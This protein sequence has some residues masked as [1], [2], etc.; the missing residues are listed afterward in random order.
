MSDLPR[1]VEFYEEGPR[2]GFQMEARHYSLEDRA[3]LVNAL[4]ET[5]LKHIQVASFVHPE[6]VP[7]MAD[8]E[9]L[10]QAITPREGVQYT[11]IWLNKRG[12]ERAAA[13]PGV[14]LCGQMVLYT[15]D[16]FCLRNNNC[17]AEEMRARQLDWLEMY[18]SYGLP[19]EEVY[20]LTAFGCNLSG[21]VP[22]S[23][24]MGCVHFITETFKKLDRPLPD[25]YLA[26]T[27]GWAN[28]EEVKRRIDAV[29]NAAPDA[30][31]GLHLHDTRGLGAANFYA[32]LEMGVSLF[33]SS[34]AGL[35]GCPFAANKDARAAGN[36]C[37]EDMVFMCEEL[38]IET[39]IHLDKL[40]EAA[41]LAEEII[42]RT[43][44]GKIMHS[45]TLSTYRKR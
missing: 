36:I 15:T 22:L 10:F 38:G 6:A 5:G 41:R 37:T 13:T 32:G 1:F 34:I 7:S 12:F 40:I 11:G 25:I 16:A 33:D 19:V 45:G 21:E 43:L 23:R 26:D 8:A 4:S 44:P 29:R 18:E 39:G 20:I 24:V 27:V 9:Q 2:E 28:P 30:R 42:G 31:L 35:G 3:K 14:S 17:T